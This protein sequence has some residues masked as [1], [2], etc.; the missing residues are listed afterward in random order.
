MSSEIDRY[1][2]EHKIDKA[3]DECIKDK[4]YY[5]GLLLSK[6]WLKSGEELSSEFKNSYNTLLG[7]LENNKEEIV[8][9]VKD[10]IRV[11]VL[12]HWAESKSICD[13]WNK[14][15]KG[16]YTWDNIQI[17]WEDPCDYYVVINC[18]HTEKDANID[19]SKTI[20]F[21]MEPHMEKASMWKDWSKPDKDIFLFAGYHEDHYNNNEWHLSK[22]YTQLMNE[23]VV[24]DTNVMNIL[25]TVLSNKYKDP[26]H[27]KR[28]DFVKFLENKGLPVHVYGGNKFEW[29][30]YKGS[31]PP[32]KK[33]E[34]LL[35][36][37]YTFNVE[38]HNI[39]GYYTEKLIDG[40]L[41][42]CLTF[43]NGCSNIRDFID[44]RAYV[45]LE[46]SNFEQDYNTIKKAI[47][48]DWWS[49]R[50]D[51]IR[52]EKRKILTE[53]QFFPRIKSIINKDIYKHNIKE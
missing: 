36:Y 4:K 12:C 22:T 10:K 34:A 29:K 18:P 17:V 19:Y 8:K 40:I 1:I 28:I 21:R 51:I 37:K 31:P 20:L 7:I 49:Q 15:S 43:Y 6:I 23:N 30:D 44:N 41:S 11:K 9:V 5:I 38:N 42:E 27:I 13:L 25:S 47:E 53:K 16:N 35:P 45:W 14:M 33:D 3:L 39:S 32:H 50:I 26:G 2:S 24:K 48:E 46:L 52:E